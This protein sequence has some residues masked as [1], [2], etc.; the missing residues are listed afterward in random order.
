MAGPRVLTDARSK[1]SKILRDHDHVVLDA[2][3]PYFSVPCA[4][5]AGVFNVLREMALSSQV[6]RQHR[7]KLRVDPKKHAALKM[8]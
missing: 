3:I 2:I 6:F 5:Q 7:W 1:K 8:A 4:L